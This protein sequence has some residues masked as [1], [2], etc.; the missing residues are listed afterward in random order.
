[1]YTS[2]FY[3]STTTSSCKTSND[4]AKNTHTL[5]AIPLQ[6]NIH[7]IVIWFYNCAVEYNFQKTVILKEKFRQITKKNKQNCSNLQGI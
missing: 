7:M 1:M 5:S 4:A 3:P 2:L 6:L